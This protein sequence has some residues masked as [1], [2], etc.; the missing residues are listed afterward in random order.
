M[1]QLLD[2]ATAEAELAKY[3]SRD[4]HSAAELMADQNGLT[5][6]DLL[7]LPGFIDFGAK[8]VTLESRI[9]KNIVLKTPFMSSPMDTV[10]EADM[11]INIALLG[12]IGIIHHNNTPEEQAA[13]V[14][15]VKKFENGFITD[16]VV[17]SPEATVSEV[18]KIKASSG[19]S[20]IPVTDNG[21]LGGK[22]LGIITSRDVAFHS[23]PQ[24]PVSQVMTADLVTAP[25]GIALKEANEIL[26]QSKKG[27]LPIVDSNGNLK[28]LLARSDLMKNLNFPLASKLPESKQL[29]CGAA[30]GTREADRARLAL[31]EQAGLDLVVLDSSQGNSVFQIDMVKW[32]KQTYPSMQVIAG[33]VVTREQAAKLIA[34]GAD[35]LR[36]GMGSGSICITQEV[37]ACGRPQATAVFQVSEFAARFGVPTVADGGLRN[38]GDIVK[39]LALGASAVMMGGMLAAVHEAPGAVIYQNGQRVKVYRGMGSIAAMEHQKGQS[40]DNAAA[41]RYYSEDDTIRV[42]QGVTGYVTEK[43]SIKEFVP[44]LTT[45]IQHSLQDIGVRSLNALRAGTQA[46]EVRFQLRSNAGIM[47]GGVGGLTSYDKQLFK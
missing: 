15:T 43:G 10:T 3:E 34:A 36:V 8:D 19:F 33:N 30:I 13:M 28:A 46:G 35:G 27:K 17:L 42:A 12:G 5:Y 37:M 18:K 39:A 44:Y 26:R 21:K 20:G 4:G 38:A 31:L 25:E 2:Y 47:E 29:Y 6:Q 23:D 41:G 16:P 24:S 32:I 11:A 1:A 14:K 7:M 40:S 22:L 9:T 45:A